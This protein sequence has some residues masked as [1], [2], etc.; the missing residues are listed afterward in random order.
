ITAGIDLALAMVAADLGEDVARKT[1]QQ[2]VVYHRRPGGQSQ[3][4]ALLE[5]ES[6]GR[7]DPLLAWARENLREP[8]TVEQLAGRVAM[9]ERSFARAF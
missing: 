6:S 2:L 7:F 8:L 9:S 5:L 4:S 3:F 1:A